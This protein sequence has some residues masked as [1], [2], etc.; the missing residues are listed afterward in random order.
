MQTWDE[1]PGFRTYRDFFAELGPSF[2]SVTVDAATKRRMIDAIPQIEF[3]GERTLGRPG[4][5]DRRFSD[6]LDDW[7]ESA[8][9]REVRKYGR[10]HYVRYEVASLYSSGEWGGPICLMA[11]LDEDFLPVRYTFIHGTGHLRHGVVA[12]DCH[13]VRFY[14]IESIRD[15]LFTLDPG[16]WMLVWNADKFSENISI[17]HVDGDDYRIGWESHDYPWY[18]TTLEWE[19]LR[20]AQCFLEKF[21]QN[22]LRGIQD[23]LTWYVEDKEDLVTSP[24]YYDESVSAGAQAVRAQRRSRK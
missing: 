24:T 19:C 22:G 23:M 8:V 14:D 18:F 21:C 4:V 1:L 3:I 15:L 6:I 12:E 17:E 10:S 9:V 2:E 5:H 7:H 16:E 11:V 20:T 13:Y